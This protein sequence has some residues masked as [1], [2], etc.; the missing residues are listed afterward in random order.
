M[1]GL[2]VDVPPKAK[3]CWE[4]CKFVVFYIFTMSP[5]LTTLVKEHP[6]VLTQHA[7]GTSN[8]AGEG[9]ELEGKSERAVM[10]MERGT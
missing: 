6:P 4:M 1:L 7:F 9:G 2:L 3:C 10:G 5:S 8:N